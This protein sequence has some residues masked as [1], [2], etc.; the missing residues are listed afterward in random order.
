L[1]ANLQQHK[2]QTSHSILWLMNW[3]AVIDP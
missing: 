2:A 3:Q 1:P